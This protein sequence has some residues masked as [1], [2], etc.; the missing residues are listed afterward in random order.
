MLSRRRC[1]C[2]GCT[3]TISGNLTGCNNMNLPG[4]TVAAHAST[5]GGTL[6]GTTTTDAS[7]NFSLV[8]ISATSGGAIVLVLS[9]PSNRFVVQNI[10]LTY[11]SGTPNSSQWSC[12]KTTAVGTKALLPATGFYCITCDVVPLP[13]TVYFSDTMWGINS[14]AL[15]YDVANNRWTSTLSYS[16][17]G[18]V[19]PGASCNCPPATV[20]IECRLGSYINNTCLAQIWY[21]SGIPLCPGATGTQT[22]DSISVNLTSAYPFFASRTLTTNSCVGCSATSPVTRTVTE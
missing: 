20:P 13:P 10:T 16:Y 11:I 2:G 17:P 15:T 19:N 9:H 22:V 12:S 6:L 5:A 18:C 7:G 4:A 8:S 21:P 14:L 3:T 1:C